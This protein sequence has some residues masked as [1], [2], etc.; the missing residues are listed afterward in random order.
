MSVGGASRT[1]RTGPERPMWTCPQCGRTFANLNQTHTCA[2]LGELDRHFAMS[3]PSVRA[4]FDRV[5]AVVRAYGPFDVLPEKTRI[6]LH[7]RMSFAAFMPRRAWLAGHLVL[8]R[9]IRSPR[10]TR[11]DVYSPRNV[12]HQF[13]LRAPDEV[14]E[15]FATWL[16]EAYQV[17]IQEHLRT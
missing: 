4:T 7:A 16:A 17:G 14:D 5:I 9:E 6:A 11:I 15:Q 13:K 1:A 2:R 8:A 10:F 12:V 3:A